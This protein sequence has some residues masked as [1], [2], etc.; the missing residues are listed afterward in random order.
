MNQ[1]ENGAFY[2]SIQTPDSGS[3]VE[4]IIKKLL[5]QIGFLRNATQK[6]NVQL[7]K[8]Q[9]KIEE[10][11]A[12][13]EAA[14]FENMPSFMRDDIIKMTLQLENLSRFLGYNCYRIDTDFPFSDYE[15]AY[16]EWRKERGEVLFTPPE[17][18][19]FFESETLFM[20]LPL[21]AVR[22]RFSERANQNPSQ[23]YC[24]L[25]TEPARYLLAN[26]AE[27]WTIDRHEFADKHLFYLFN[28]DPKELGPRDNDNFD[29][30]AVQNAITELLPAGDAGTHCSAS[31]LSINDSSIPY[32]TYITLTSGLLNQPAVDF[33]VSQ[34]KKRFKT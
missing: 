6:V 12:E 29:I 17:Y 11:E 34:W 25:D 1:K 18:D 16:S 15:Y 32:G 24:L 3:S 13:N 14:S 5:F 8:I 21:S 4:F 33:V 20:K 23:K 27:F 30:H 26:C 19:C 7:E 9:A 28:W 31:M 10:I 22:A 2:K